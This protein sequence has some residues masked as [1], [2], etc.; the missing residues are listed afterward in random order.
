MNI[1]SNM[2]FISVCIFF[3][4]LLLSVIFSDFTGS[5]FE[6][7]FHPNYGWWGGPELVVIPFSYVFFIVLFF[8]IWNHK[9]YY[10]PMLVFLSPVILL[11]L[12]T[13]LYGFNSSDILNLGGVFV[14]PGI[15]AFALAKLINLIISKF[16]HPNPPMVVK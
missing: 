5:M 7:L 12:L 8:A 10:Y 15:I 4:A 3:S 2:P 16:K 13:L 6:K 14:L 11:M 1:K 9:K